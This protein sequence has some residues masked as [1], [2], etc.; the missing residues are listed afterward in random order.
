MLVSGGVYLL[1]KVPKN[2]IYTFEKINLQIHLLGHF[3]RP[4]LWPKVFSAV[5]MRH[6]SPMDSALGH[7][8][9]V[10]HGFGDCTIHE[11]IWWRSKR[12]TN[13]TNPRQPK[14][15]HKKKIKV[16]LFWK[17][18]SQDPLQETWKIPQRHQPN[19]P[20]SSPQDFF[21]K[22]NGHVHQMVVAKY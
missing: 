13:Q 6:S 8:K 19:L 11:T 5:S 3:A 2:P 14:M 21:R 9:P 22:K 18:F 7:E 16:M 4:R 12:Q 1:G 10:N 15:N 20:R 17:I